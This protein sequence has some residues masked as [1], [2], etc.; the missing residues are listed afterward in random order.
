MPLNI[1]SL[2]YKEGKQIR[3]CSIKDIAF[4]HCQDIETYM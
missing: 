2:D 4:V 1:N 3:C